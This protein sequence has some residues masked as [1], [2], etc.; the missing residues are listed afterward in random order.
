MLEAVCNAAEH[1]KIGIGSSNKYNARNP[2]TPEETQEMIDVVLRP[3]FTNYE[4]VMVPD[5]GHLPGGE[6]GQQW[7][8]SVHA[9]FGS[10]DA[11]VTGNPYVAKLLDQ[12]YHTVHPADLIAK[13][14]HVALRGTMVRVALAQGGHWKQMVPGPV[15]DYLELKGLVERFRNEFGLVTLASLVKQGIKSRES[16]HEEQQHTYEV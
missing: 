9:L 5:S 6:D 8:Q 11:F 14:N 10:L 7:A 1:A 12:F 15:A 2:F 4:V 13:E 3:N 16:L